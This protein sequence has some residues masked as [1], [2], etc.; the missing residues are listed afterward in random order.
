LH[1]AY[2]RVDDAITHETFSL[3]RCERCGLGQTW[4]IPADLS[5]YYGPRYH[6][7]RHGVTEQWAIRRRLR[8]AHAVSPIP[9]SV[10]D[11]GCGD[12]TFLLAMRKRG[13]RVAGT[14]LNPV[15]AREGGLPVV[16]SLDSLAR[17]Q[18]PFQLITLWHSLE[19]LPEPRRALEQLTAHL[20]LGGTL[21]VA[22]PNADGWQARMFGRHWLHLDMPRHL[23]HFGP[24]SLTFLFEVL[25]L[26]PVR[27]WDAELE[28]DWMGWAQSALDSVSRQS[29]DRLV[30]FDWLRG[31]PQNLPRWQQL[32]HLTAGVCV[33]PAS[34]AATAAGTLAGQGGTLVMAARKVVDAPVG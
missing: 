8:W 13:W 24:Q 17:L 30:L 3:L 10:L 9:A 23:F 7:G 4:P 33:A 34:L 6:G 5:R 22:V 11:V 32:A 31:R 18:P 1:E 16:E 26:Q 15:R 12:G 27:R 29:G 21:L 20:A 28:Y 2:D 25:Q 19:H 14:E